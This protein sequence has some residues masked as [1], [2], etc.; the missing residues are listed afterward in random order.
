MNL[1]QEVQA[2]AISGVS[3]SE[4][5][6]VSITVDSGASETVA[7]ESMAKAI[8]VDSSPG[9]LRGAKYEV[10]NGHIIHNKG[11]KRC[12]LQ[13]DGGTE[14]LLS[15]QV[16]DVHKPLLA[17]SKLCEIG[18]AVVFHPE[19]S[20]IENLA[21]GERMTLEKKDGLYELRAWVKSA[22]NTGD[23]GHSSF[24]GPGPR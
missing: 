24:G 1:L 22:K 6:E 15:F 20:F 4:W 12:I 3:M 23:G 19:W 7:P 13:N 21:T 18:H 10:A 17:V 11:E 8:P 5:E 14:K 9:S 16:C 2:G